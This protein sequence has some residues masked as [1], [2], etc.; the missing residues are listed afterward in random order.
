MSAHKIETGFSESWQRDRVEIE[1]IRK[2][3]EF[4]TYAPTG[5]YTVS[6]PGEAT[7]EWKLP[8][9]MLTTGDPVGWVL[10]QFPE[11]K[12]THL[13]TKPEDKGLSAT[14][15]VSKPLVSK[16]VSPE[17]FQEPAIDAHKLADILSAYD[18]GVSM[19]SIV[20]NILGCK[21]ALF[22]K[23]RELYFKVIQ[24]HRPRK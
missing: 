5:C 16:L 13:V 15:E 4:G 12:H 14:S 22:S 17:V 23:G 2:A 9:W 20:E 18:A 1:A 24:E 8:E 11:L 21:G 10:E 7:C 6:L 19:T 3:D